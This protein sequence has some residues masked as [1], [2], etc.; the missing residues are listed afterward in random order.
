MAS[1][2]GGV[3]PQ[4]APSAHHRAAESGWIVFA[5]V[6]MIF[7]GLLALSQGI[8]AIRND[9]VFVVTR[10]Y[11]FAFDL[12]GW[13]WV[14]AIVGALAVVA[15]AALFTGAMW[16]RV[17]G[18]V[19]AGLSLIANFLWLP[20]YPVWAV[21]LLILDALVIWALCTGPGMAERAQREASMGQQ[22]QQGQGPPVTSR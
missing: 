14:H 13:G 12:T 21:A 16:A 10:H 11:A 20:Y 18:V 6:M 5:A 17:V 3:Q 9:Q 8:S 4:A 15:G 7:A 22:G 19:L 2:V 1:H